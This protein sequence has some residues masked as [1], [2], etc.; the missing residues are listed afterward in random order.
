MSDPISDIIT[1]VYVKNGNINIRVEDGERKSSIN[2]T[3]EQAYHF[4][5]ELVNYAQQCRHVDGKYSK[6]IKEWR[7]ENGYD[8]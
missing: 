6:R 3:P 8:D 7:E 2:L 1:D 5:Y 4:A